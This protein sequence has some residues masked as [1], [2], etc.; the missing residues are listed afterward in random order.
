M[1]VI[2]SDFAYDAK[3]ERIV[4]M[5][6]AADSRKFYRRIPWIKGKNGLTGRVINIVEGSV[7]DNAGVCGNDSHINPE[8]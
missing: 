1:T 4:Y 5:T 8:A 7:G 3:Y 6:I 2:S